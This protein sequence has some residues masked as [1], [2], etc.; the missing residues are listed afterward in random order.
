MIGGNGFAYAQARMQTRLGARPSDSAW[1]ALAANVE[2]RS[3]LEHARTTPLRPWLSSLAPT[4]D[5]HE[6]ERILRA[7]LRERVN[8]VAGWVPSPWRD[9]VRF[10]ALAVDLPAMEHLLAGG[11]PLP[12]MH[13]EASLTGGAARAT[14]AGLARQAREGGF[15]RT[16][17]GADLSRRE[18]W[19][20]AWRTRLPRT[21]PAPARR[22]ERL[23]ELLR[24]HL[25]SRAGPAE[26]RVDRHGRR[27]R[28]FESRVV[29]HFR[30][31]LMEPAAVFAYLLLVALEFER[32]R[33]ALV[34]RLLFAARAG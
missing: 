21:A 10:A 9:A 6:T 25:D 1:L 12:W 5:A 2:F 22:I 32:L 34:G 26:A 23:V 3:Y 15:A 18:Y 19:I 33:G 8:E 7:R 13:Q 31:A 29:G 14:R 17:V 4:A 11:E 20:A 24:E 28:D 30:R 27:D 16:R